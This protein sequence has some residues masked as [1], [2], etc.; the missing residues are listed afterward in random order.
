MI[1]R[2]KSLLGMK[3]NDKKPNKYLTGC[4]DRV[5]KII[6]EYE[7]RY[8]TDIGSCEKIANEVEGRFTGQDPFAKDFFN[9]VNPFLLSSPIVE[10][11]KESSGD[12]EED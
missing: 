1:E 11:T 8:P 5:K 6:Q 9:G 10:H 7:R 3:H 2:A 12:K 4:V